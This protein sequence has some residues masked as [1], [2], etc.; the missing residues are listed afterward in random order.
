M[1]DLYSVAEAGCE[2]S[3]YSSWY[4]QKG[5]AAAVVQEKTGA[6]CL[7]YD[8]AG[9][10]KSEGLPSVRDV[11]DDARAAYNYLFDELHVDPQTRVQCGGSLGTGLAVKMAAEKTAAGVMLFSPYTS[12][13]DVARE[14]F[15]FLKYY[16]DF[17]LIDQ[18]LE[19]LA[20]IG[21]V[22]C[23]LLIVHGVQDGM[24]GVDHGDR[25]F[26]AANEPKTYCRIEDGGHFGCG[27][28]G[29]AVDQFLRTLK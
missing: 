8:Y 21:R 24:I 20:T 12:L 17:L 3:P 13:K 18:D 2:D 7:I 5:K 25:I 4:R 10:G 23:P 15:S 27:F 22:K 26:A 19:S 16:P 14:K 29:D 11:P 9:F 28:Q 6:A 1:A